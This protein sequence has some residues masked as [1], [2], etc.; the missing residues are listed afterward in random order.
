MMRPFGR[1]I[2]YLYMLEGRY[3]LVTRPCKKQTG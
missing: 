3:L 2:K 1:Y